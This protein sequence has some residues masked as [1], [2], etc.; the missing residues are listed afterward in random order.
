MVFKLL[1][2]AEPFRR[3]GGRVRSRTGSRRRLAIRPRGGPRPATSG[4]VCLVGSSPDDGPPGRRDRVRRAIKP[5]GVSRPGHAPSRRRLP[6]GQSATAEA[7][8]YW[9]GRAPKSMDGRNRGKAPTIHR[10][11]LCQPAPSWGPDGLK[12]SSD[13]LQHVVGTGAAHHDGV[14]RGRLTRGG[15]CLLGDVTSQLFAVLGGPSST[16]LD[17]NSDRG[18]GSRD[19]GRRTCCD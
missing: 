17:G 14:D 18:S 4:S 13:S 15:V 8:G 10:L 1:A 12:H 16:V 19:F 7:V 11:H 3:R 9:P 5:A 2:G 6:F